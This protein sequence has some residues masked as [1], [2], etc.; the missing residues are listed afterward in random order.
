MRRLKSWLRWLV[1]AAATGI[2]GLSPAAGQEACTP[3]QQAF[4]AAYWASQPPAV[5]ALQGNT[6]GSKAASVAILGYTIDTQTMVWGWDPCLVMSLRKGFGYT[7]VPNALQAG[8]QMAP[9]NTS[10]GNLI[11]YD[12]NNPPAGAI[13][14]STDAADFKPFD[15]PP[16]PKAPVVITNPVGA[17]SFGNI[18]LAVA[19]DASPDG[20]TFTDERG[21]FIK[22]MVATPFGRNV[23]WEKQ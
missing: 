12:P 22:R 10:P 16:P 18:Y 19:G 4:D 7:W 15:P 3:N 14:V 17:Q 23:Y 13:K 5:R 20:T 9:G 6:D 2:A 11:P 8:V 1:I 21:T